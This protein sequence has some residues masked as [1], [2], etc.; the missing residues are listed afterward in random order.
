MKFTMVMHRIKSIPLLKQALH[1]DHN[2]RTKSDLFVSLQM[3]LVPVFGDNTDAG[4]TAYGQIKTN[5][6]IQNKTSGLRI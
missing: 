4:K 6:T 2:D 1:Y 3:A 5:A